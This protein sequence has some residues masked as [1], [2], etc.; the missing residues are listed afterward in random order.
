MKLVWLLLD[1]FIRFY[2]ITAL[3]GT[4]SIF[5]KGSNMY[6]LVLFL[7]L[8]GNSL[9]IRYVSCEF[10]CICSLLDRASSL[11]FFTCFF[12]KVLDFVRYFF[13]AYWC[14]YVFPFLW[15]ATQDFCC[16]CC[17]NFAWNKLY[18]VM[19]HITT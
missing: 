5:I 2:Y 19:M 17:C 15:H 6:I 3:T 13:W 11:L 16:C 12:H 4:S 9:T 14:S 7:M 8:K 10:L 1:A 18:L